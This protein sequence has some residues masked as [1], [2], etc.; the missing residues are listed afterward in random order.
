M[1]AAAV[2][3]KILLSAGTH[4]YKYNFKKEIEDDIKSKGYRVV[5]LMEAHKSETPWKDKW[6][7]NF[8][9]RRRVLY[10]KVTIANEEGITTTHYLRYHYNSGLPDCSEFHPPLA[11]DSVEEGGW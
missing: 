8:L 9:V 2:I 3:L 7:F 11:D 1:A 5:E 6:D 4:L 10:K